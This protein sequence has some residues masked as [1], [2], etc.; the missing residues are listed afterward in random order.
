MRFSSASVVQSGHR[1]KQPA[2][3]ADQ[4]GRRVIDHRYAL[5]RHKTNLLH[6][7]FCLK[8]RGKPNCKSVEE[9]SENEEY[10]S[11]ELTEY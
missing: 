2:Q 8:G 11:L 3:T 10:D 7:N 4:F 6:A 9:H 5:W 1:G